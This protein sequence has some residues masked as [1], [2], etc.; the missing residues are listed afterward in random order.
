MKRLNHLEYTVLWCIM[1]ACIFIIAIIIT[2]STDP[3]HAMPPASA[4]SPEAGQKPITATIWCDN[5]Y[6]KIDAIGTVRAAAN[7]VTFTDAS[8]GKTVVI[9][10][11]FVI[12]YNKYE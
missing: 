12:K 6:T 7:Y 2:P 10:G 9:S 5:G 3:R 8:T 4:I 11:N 1:I